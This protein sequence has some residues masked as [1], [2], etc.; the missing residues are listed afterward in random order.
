MNRPPEFQAWIFNGIESFLS[1]DEIRLNLCRYDGRTSM[2][3]VV[4]HPIEARPHNE[5]EK[6]EPFLKLPREAA[7]PILRAIRDAIDKFD[8]RKESPAD[9]LRGQITRLTDEVEW[10]RKQVE[11]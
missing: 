3:Y 2:H 4:A 10:L 11:K 8:P 6:I 5:G 9:E 7:L 1:T